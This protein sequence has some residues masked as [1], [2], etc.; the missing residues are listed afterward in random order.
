[1]D[2]ALK[3]LP[4]R[5]TDGWAEVPMQ[6][7]LWQQTRKT[8]KEMDVHLT[9]AGALGYNVGTGPFCSLDARSANISILLSRPWQNLLFERNP[10]SDDATGPLAAVRGHSQSHGCEKLGESGTTS[11][12]SLPFTPPPPS[13]G[14]DI[15]LGIRKR[16]IHRMTGFR[17][18]CRGTRG[19]CRVTKRAHILR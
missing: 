18:W 12:S 4:A 17:K 10:T 19:L 9:A 5:T 14:S 7:R 1:M 13:L 11:L 15:H 2:D 3:K 6:A 16:L 8:N